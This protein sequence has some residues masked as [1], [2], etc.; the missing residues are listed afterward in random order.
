MLIIALSSHSWV[1][2]KIKHILYFGP[3]GCS[4]P[5]SKGCRSCIPKN[6]GSF[7]TVSY[8]SGMGA[9]GVP[10]PLGVRIP[11]G[12]WKLEDYFSRFQ[13]GW[14]LGEPPGKI[15][16]AVFLDDDKVTVFALHQFGNTGI[17]CVIIL[18]SPRG[19]KCHKGNPHWR[20]RECKIKLERK[21][22]I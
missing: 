2:K 18:R 6:G 10:C 20:V 8:G 11:T 15:F 12:S 3:S 4:F 5:P 22:Q 14:C 21:F 16:K 1:A 17:S 19:T 9:Q 13:I 7:S